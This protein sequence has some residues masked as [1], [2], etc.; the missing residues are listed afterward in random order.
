MKIFF[1]VYYSWKKKIMFSCNTNLSSFFSVFSL[2]CAFSLFVNFF[3]VSSQNWSGHSKIPELP[4]LRSMSS[5]EPGF[6]CYPTSREWNSLDRMEDKQDRGL[7][8]MGIQFHAD[9]L[10]Q[11]SSWGGVSSSVRVYRKTTR[12]KIR[13]YFLELLKQLSVIAIDSSCSSD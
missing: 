12:I 6:L 9:P 8:P 5:E 4:V 1:R 13:E 11:H 7:Q 10:R 2:F 3:A